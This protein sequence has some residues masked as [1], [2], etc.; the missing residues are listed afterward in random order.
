ME[1]NSQRADLILPEH[2]RNIQ[3]MVQYAKTLEDRDERS[4]AVSKVVKIIAQ[5]NPQMKDN[6]EFMHKIWD[7]VHMMA[8]YELDIDAPYPPPDKDK[9][10]RKPEK[11]PYNQNNIAYKHYGK[12][13]ELMVKKACAMKPGPSRDYFINAIASYMK[14]S[15]R[16]WNDEKVSDQVIL[17]HLKELSGGQLEL[18]NL[19]EL[20]KN[21]DPN[22]SRQKSGGGKGHQNNKGHQKNQGHKG[23]KHK[24]H[25]KNKKQ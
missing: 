19:I 15:Y 21:Y 3:R 17:N 9:I 22:Q 12:N 2:G 24:N 18:D 25:K 20:N 5:M 23:P 10:E 11:L 1:Y 8:D 4:R 7:H 6:P 16:T 14:M 13:I